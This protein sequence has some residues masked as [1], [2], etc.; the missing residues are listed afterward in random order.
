MRR[1][2]RAH[3]QPL[4]FSRVEHFM[5]FTPKF[6][7][8]AKR[9]RRPKS[10]TPQ[11]ELLENRLQPSA[12]FLG[13]EL[14]LLSNLTPLDPA[15]LKPADEPVHLPPVTGVVHSM[16]STPA[17]AAVPASS[18]QT[19]G[20]GAVAQPAM[21]SASGSGSA[22]FLPNLGLGQAGA[23]SHSATAAPLVGHPTGS[24]TQSA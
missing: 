7:S 20:Q 5:R 8:S 21:P 12:A 1:T 17:A 15:W 10:A 11:V 22:P 3:N 6:L 2:G 19:S 4:S 13:Q 23:Q 14:E 24:Q 18:G 9:P 16:S